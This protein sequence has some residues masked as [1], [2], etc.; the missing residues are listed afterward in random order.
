M[1]ADSSDIS[2]RLE[3]IKKLC[4]ELEDARND[5]RKYQRLITR[6]RAEAEAFRQTLGTHDR[7]DEGKP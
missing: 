1:S 2:E 7:H 3:R 5:T 6:I 4:D